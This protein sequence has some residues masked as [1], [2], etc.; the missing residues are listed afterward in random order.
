MP[1]LPLRRRSLLQTGFALGTAAFL[2]AA[3]A[4]EYFAPN[5]TVHHPWARASAPGATSAIV[6]MTID[7]VSQADRLVGVRTPVATGAEMG[8]PGVGP[9][10]DIAIPQGQTTELNEAGVHLR[11]VGLTM[12]LEMAREYPLTLIFARA[13]ALPAKLLIDFPAER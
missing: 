4:H 13:G 9:K 6:S 5:F 11:L 7:E 2:P 1:A 10:L 8:G 3:W 12:P